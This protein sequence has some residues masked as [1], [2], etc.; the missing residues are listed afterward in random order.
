MDPVDSKKAVDLPAL[1][2]RVS[3]DGGRS[4]MAMTWLLA[5]SLIA[6]V[7]AV[8]WAVNAA[9]KRDASGPTNPNPP[10]PPGD[11]KPGRQGY[12]VEIGEAPVPD[13]TM[14][15]P[16][17]LDKEVKDKIDDL[18]K[19]AAND[20][21]ADG[22]PVGLKKR[23]GDGLGDPDAQ[24]HRRWSIEWGQDTEVG[25]R[26]KLFGIVIGAVRGGQLLGAKSRFAAGTPE[27]VAK[28][29]ERWFVHQDRTRV[30]LDRKL[31]SDAG[32]PV[33]ATDVV[34]QFFP[35]ELSDKLAAVEKGH[36]HKNE[37]DIE[38]TVF[39]V[40]PAGA[41]FEFYVIEQRLK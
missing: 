34:A 24:R 38:R 19:I 26:R 16:V 2:D 33:A 18:L 25:Y 11:D 31:L 40:R 32:V 20:P 13:D 14:P 39:G 1:E 35:R 8:N 30:E 4:S 36:S 15:A 28:P 10:Q 3:R 41:G 12:A 23:L 7:Y 9:P 17:D 27:T 29:P 6:I 22:G 37:S 21:V 5:L